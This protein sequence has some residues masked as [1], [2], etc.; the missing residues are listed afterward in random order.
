MKPE[1]MIAIGVGS[2]GFILGI[3]N[4]LWGPKLLTRRLKVEIHEP[5]LEAKIIKQKNEIARIFI[6]AEFKLVRTRGEDDV[7]FKSAYVSLDNKLYRQLDHVFNMP[8]AG[9]IYWTKST[10]IGDNHE[11]WLKKL[12]P[13]PLAIA[14]SCDR[15]DA[16]SNLDK[17]VL[18]NLEEKVKQLESKYK[19]YWIDSKENK[20]SYRLPH[21]WWGKFVPEILY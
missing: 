12:Q 15:K 21:K 1:V 19:I 20:R 14:V 7:Y 3:I 6:R 11:D 16:L 9:K 4:L 5:T 10:Y 18:N 17:E 2:A 13:M 8:P